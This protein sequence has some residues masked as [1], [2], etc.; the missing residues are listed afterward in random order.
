VSAAL[1]LSALAAAI[2]GTAVLL[3][4][5]RGTQAAAVAAS[6]VMAAAMADLTFWRAVPAVWWVAAQLALAVVLAVVARC[7]GARPAADGRAA[8][9]AVC[10]LAVHTALGLVVMAACAATMGGAGGGAGVVGGAMDGVIGVR[11]HDH[12]SPM[13]LLV[14]LGG[15]VAGW[16]VVTAR[17]M[18]RLPHRRHRVH[19]GL[20]LASAAVMLVAVA[21]GT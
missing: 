5:P 20:M 2:V 10:P 1:H 19:A 9:G 6:V 3:V 15:L 13:G 7:A 8:R 12:T 11:G 21:A 17:H 18:R 14:V 4:R 16:A